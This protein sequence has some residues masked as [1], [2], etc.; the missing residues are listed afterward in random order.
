VCFMCFFRATA[1]GSLTISWQMRQLKGAT[2]DRW[3]PSWDS[4]S[5]SVAWGSPQNEQGKAFVVFV[6]FP[7]SSF[8]ETPP[9]LLPLWYFLH[10]IGRISLPVS[11]RIF[12]KYST[13]IILP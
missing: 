3:R 4:N 6:V 5:A 10:D 12:S 7:F 13:C 2:R 8:E 9:L 11:R 1:F